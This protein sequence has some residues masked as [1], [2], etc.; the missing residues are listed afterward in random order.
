MTS[1]LFLLLTKITATPK[2]QNHSLK[3]NTRITQLSADYKSRKNRQSS[4]TIIPC[5]Q[6][7]PPVVK[8]PLYASCQ[9]VFREKRGQQFARRQRTIAGCARWKQ[10][11]NVPEVRGERVAPLRRCLPPESAGIC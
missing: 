1:L 2:V 8:T 3:L 4:Y 11:T 6:Q 7:T 9:D 10:N 5:S